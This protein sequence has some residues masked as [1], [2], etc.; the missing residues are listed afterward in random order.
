MHFASVNLEFTI[1]KCVCGGRTFH[2]LTRGILV[3]TSNEL[4]SGSPH[5][6]NAKKNPKKTLTHVWSFKQRGN[7]DTES[8]PPFFLFVVKSYNIHRNEHIK[9]FLL[10]CLMNLYIINCKD[11]GHSH[12]HLYFFRDCIQIITVALIFWVLGKSREAGRSSELCLCLF[13][14]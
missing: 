7:L 12:P 11:Q 2:C 6:L 1:W 4:C 5:I 14:E 3:T 8:F 9:Y 10:F 13:S